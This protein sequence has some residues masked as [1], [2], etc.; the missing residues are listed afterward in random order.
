MTDASTSDTIQEVVDVVSATGAMCFIDHAHDRPDLVVVDY[1][2]GVFTLD[3]PR[4][5]VTIEAALRDLNRKIAAMSEDFPSLDD[6]PVQRIV[7]TEAARG[8]SAFGV[9][10][11]LAAELGWFEQLEQKKLDKRLFAEIVEGLQPVI[12]M[13]VPQRGVPTDQGSDER[14]AARVRLDESQ[15]KA[16]IRKV[17]DVLVITGPAGSGKSLVLAA[18]ARWIAQTRPNWRVQ[19]LCFNRALVTYLYSLIGDFPNVTVEIYSEYAKRLGFPTEFT[20][21]AKADDLL[22]KARRKGIPYGCDALLIDEWQDFFPSWTQ[23]AL[24]SLLPGRGG[25][26]FAADGKQ[27]LYRNC[28]PKAALKGHHLEQV[29]LTQPYRSTRQILEVVAA[30]DPVFKISGIEDS[31]DGAPVELV[32]ADTFIA[33]AEA[34]VRDV[35]VQ[36]GEGRALNDVAILVTS[37]WMYKP[38]LAMLHEHAVPFELVTK[39]NQDFLDLTTPTVKVMTV[40][41]AKGLEFGLI[42]LLGLEQLDDHREQGIDAVEAEQRKHRMRLGLVGPSRAKDMLMIYYSKH[43]VFLERLKNSNAP[44]RAWIYPDD[45][46]SEY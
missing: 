9:T 16:A 40:H 19:V 3:F 41:K 24:E 22:E 20:D 43:N 4:A 5:G 26:V 35:R 2:R 12:P 36:L 38:L 33:Q 18:R 42:C 13:L 27:A 15:A 10:P 44:F 11:A 37:R 8:R 1:E 29:E 17:D 30:L 46:G 14:A 34:A 32:R 25:A 23:F 45:Y 21:R 39:E 31:P 6:L 7:V 28:E